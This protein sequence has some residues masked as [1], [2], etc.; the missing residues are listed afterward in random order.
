VTE[1]A[2]QFIKDLGGG[3]LLR[4]AAPA[5]ADR[6]AE[7]DGRI[8][9]DDAYD[10]AAVA[11]WVRD[12]LLR[13][14]PTFQPGDFTIVEEP[15]T[16]R[17]VSSLNAISQTWAYEGIPF[18]VSRPELVGTEPEYRNHGLV[19]EQFN[20]IHEWS[21]RRGELV[22]VITGIPFYYRQ[23]GYEMALELSGGR[24]G[25]QP[26]VPALR[27]GEAEPYH[28]RPAGEADLPFL[29]RLYDQERS[30][31]AISAVRDEAL[32]RN[33][34]LERSPENVNR[35]EFRVIEDRAGRPAGYFAH[36]WY[37]W[38]NMQAVYRYELEKGV[39]YAAVTP[40]LIR[41]IWQ[42]GQENAQRREKT[43]TSFGLW[44]GSDHPAYHAVAGRLAFTRPP[45][46]F[47][48]RVLDLPAFLGCIAPALEKRLS[49]STCPGYSGELKIS[50][51]RA[52]VRLLFEGGRLVKAEAWKPV[53]N[54]DQGN[55]AFPNLSFLQ[56]V[57]GFRS[58]EEIRYAY[59]DCWASDETGTLLETLFPKKASSV[60]VVS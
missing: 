44:F 27:D 16:G 50:F 17:I 19:R 8:H 5:D 23:F 60:W 58:L 4:H 25:Y 6:L 18:G 24:G 11:S 39:S 3:L 21:R 10:S 22:Q 56:L 2:R 28:I 40:S 49:E 30:R 48:V 12:L 43:L 53:I 59:P 47:Y 42:V 34:L 46:A 41:Y 51:Y 52:G 57:F 45:Y 38:G 31:S 13:P 20:V 32:W 29:M 54:Q 26:Q 15:L 37:T 55:A 1:R 36:P 35:L 7:F 33:E 9:G 14:H